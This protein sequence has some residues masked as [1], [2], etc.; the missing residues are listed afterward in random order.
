MVLRLTP[1]ARKDD[2]KDH[3]QSDAEKRDATTQ[4]PDNNSQI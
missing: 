2:E 4:Y 1:G 3:S